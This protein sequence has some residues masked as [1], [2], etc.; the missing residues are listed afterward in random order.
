MW[1]SQGPGA[2][3]EY[4]NAW[5]FAK[6][7]V[8]GYVYSDCSLEMLE[9]SGYRYADTRA[10]HTDAGV[11]LY[12]AHILGRVWGGDVSNTDLLLTRGQHQ[13]AVME[14]C[15]RRHACSIVMW[16]AL[17]FSDMSAIQCRWKS[18]SIV[19]LHGPTRLYLDP[20]SLWDQLKISFDPHNAQCPL[21][22]TFDLLSLVRKPF[23][24]C[25]GRQFETLVKVKD[26][27]NAL[28]VGI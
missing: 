25:Y 24:H 14:T 12:A 5:L 16:L 22:V 1:H 27:P 4:T 18:E 20:N 9:C 11:L 21:A 2:I 13:Y 19:F 15:T 3:K 6:S 23:G 28:F 17:V 7:V 8:I 10:G 26:M